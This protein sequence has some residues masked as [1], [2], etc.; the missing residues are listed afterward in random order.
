VQQPSESDPARFRYGG[1][2]GR[3]EPA[4]AVERLGQLRG[5]ESDANRELPLGAGELLDQLADA[6]AYRLFGG[7]H[8]PRLAMTCD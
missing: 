3:G 5:F 8:G 1:E 7:W 2:L 6:F 4:L